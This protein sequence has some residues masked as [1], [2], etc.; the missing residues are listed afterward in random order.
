MTVCCD[1]VLWLCAV[2]VCCDYLAC[3]DR[4]AAAAARSTL[5]FGV[6]SNGRGLIDV[7]TMMGQ[8]ATAEWLVQIHGKSPFEV[9]VACR[10]PGCGNF[11]IVSRHFTRIF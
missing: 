10:N 3:T 2:A 6:T 11:D 5:S 4:G 9:A 7:A 8:D 1:C